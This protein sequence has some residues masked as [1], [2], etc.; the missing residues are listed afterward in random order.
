[1]KKKY[2]FLTLPLVA[3]A[4][5]LSLNAYAEYEQE[6][7]SQVDKMMGRAKSNFSEVYF[8]DM[9]IIARKADLAELNE[10]TAKIVRTYL[11]EKM[12]QYIQQK[13]KDINETYLSDPA[14]ATSQF[15]ELVKFQKYF[16]PTEA[17]LQTA[18]GRA[19]EAELEQARKH[20][21]E[22]L[23]RGDSKESLMTALEAVRKT[24]F[25]MT[26]SGNEYSS[27]RELTQELECSFGWKSKINYHYSHKFE[28]D[29]DAGTID[30]EAHLN[31]ESS[32][33]ELSEAKWSGEW[34]YH[35]KGRDGTVEAVSHATLTH[36]KGQDIAELV[37]TS[38]KVSSIGRMNMP[39]PV[40]GDMRTFEVKGEPFHPWVA[41]T[42]MITVELVGCRENK[43]KP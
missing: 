2:F 1:M 37:I 26:N 18:E 28:T 13:I 7:Q 10:M 15:L 30:E 20:A 5:F 16:Q 34:I 24:G 6:I 27:M 23:K 3:A 32:G 35:M 17:F 12:S 39:M 14:Q 33:K 22:D 11:F 25:F 40:S 38:A 31:L 8:H 21:L 29:Y 43:V 42:G 41:L 9:G 19:I 4:F 36:R